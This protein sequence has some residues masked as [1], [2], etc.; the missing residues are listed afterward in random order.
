LESK[1]GF[2]HKNPKWLLQL[3]R[4]ERHL[5]GKLCCFERKKL[6]IVQKKIDGEVQDGVK[7]QNGTQK[8][9]NLVIQRVSKFVYD[10]FTLL[11]SKTV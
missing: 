11:V 8:R 2:G 1:I 10:L 9:K 7:T 5:A 4:P 6:T 3:Y